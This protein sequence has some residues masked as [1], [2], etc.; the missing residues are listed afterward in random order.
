MA[1]EVGLREGDRYLIVNP[2]FHCFGLKAGIVA[3]LIKGVTIVP[4]PSST[5]PA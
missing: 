3:C 4:T 2:F 1:T 5:C